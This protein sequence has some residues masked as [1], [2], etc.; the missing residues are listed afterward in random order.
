MHSLSGK[1]ESH[2]SQTTHADTFYRRH[3]S[4][5]WCC[6]PTHGVAGKMPSAPGADDSGAS[7][8]PKTAPD[9]KPVLQERETVQKNLKE[10]VLSANF[11]F[12]YEMQFANTAHGKKSKLLFGV[13]TFRGAGSRHRR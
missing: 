9:M 6:S 1:A 5:F 3:E 12:R 7:M 13:Q 8:K 11:R 4:S 2:T 10:E